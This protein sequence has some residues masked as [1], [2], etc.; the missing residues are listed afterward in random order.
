[1]GGLVKL[2]NFFTKVNNRL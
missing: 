1:V 2:V